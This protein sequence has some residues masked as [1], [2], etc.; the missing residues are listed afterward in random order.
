MIHFLAYDLVEALALPGCPLCRA[1][2][3]DEERWMRSFWREGRAGR[4]ARLAFYD[5]GGFCGRHA[6][7]LHRVSSEEGSGAAIADVYGA[8]ADRDLAWLDAQLA[9][10]RPPAALDRGAPCSACVAAADAVSRKAFFLVELVGS[11]EARRRYVESDGL[12][13]PHLARAVE[14]AGDDD[15]EAVKLLLRDWRRRL[16]EVRTRLDEFDRK[17]DVRYAHEAK[18]AEQESWTDVIRLYAGER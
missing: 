7:L 13:F 4:D 1:V 6:W 15:A 18:G 3:A 16:A 12:C 10:R 17:R 2:R 11:R 9:R 5:G 14:E 8:L